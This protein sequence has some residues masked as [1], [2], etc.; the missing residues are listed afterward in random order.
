V[1]NSLYPVDRTATIVASFAACGDMLARLVL[2]AVCGHSDGGGTRC[3]RTHDSI[4][5]RILRLASE[6]PLTP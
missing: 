3:A 1:G 6:P 2:F 5:E 4:V